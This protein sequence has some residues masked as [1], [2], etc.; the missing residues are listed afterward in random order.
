MSTILQNAVYV[1]E[2]RRYYKSGNTHDFVSLKLK[3]GKEFFI[4]GGT[5]YFRAGGHLTEL[6]NSGRVIKFHLTSDDSFTQAIVPKL[7]WGTRGKDGKQPLKF[8]PMNSFESDHLQAILDNC[9]YAGQLHRL[10]A[11]HI[12]Q[13]RK[14]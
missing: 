13:E 4:D 14:R 2:E 3:G 7:L 9:P 10:V 8:L 11:H 12:L 1:P 6:Y 5:S